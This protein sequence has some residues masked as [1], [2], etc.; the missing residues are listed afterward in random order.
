MASAALNHYT[1]EEYLAL[2]RNAEFRN[3]YING[4]IIAMSP[5]ATRPHNLIVARLVYHLEAQLQNG[6]CEVY[7]STQRVKVSAS[8]DYLYPDVAVSCNP[9]F[10]DGH[11]GNLLTPIVLMEVLSDSTERHDRT[12]KLALYRPIETLREYVL[13]SQK[14]PLVER[15]VREGEFWQARSVAG[16]DAELVLFSVGV[17][18]PLEQVYSRALLPTRRVPRAHGANE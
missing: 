2:E 9:V 6:P 16:L 18:I 14:E 11:F 3:E 15:Y 17:Q 1:P 13:I 12:Q 8:G 5:G 10:E 7:T 4:Y